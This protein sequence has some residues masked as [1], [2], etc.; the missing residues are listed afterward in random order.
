MYKVLSSDEL[1]SGKLYR[2]EFDIDLFFLFLLEGKESVD[3]RDI[4][5]EKKRRE[6]QEWLQKDLV[7]DTRETWREWLKR[8][9]DMGDAPLVPREE[10]PEKYQPH[11]SFY[12]RI[13]NMANGINPTPRG[14]R[15]REFASNSSE[16]VD[17]ELAPQGSAREAE[18][19]G[20]AS[21]IVVSNN[22]ESD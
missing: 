10:L 21:K 12:N 7:V 5:F 14:Q 9:R 18:Y 20:A 22:E 19:T 6:Y 11:A 17:I 4:F 3:D 13:V 15:R 16:V 1:G 8:Q 2:E